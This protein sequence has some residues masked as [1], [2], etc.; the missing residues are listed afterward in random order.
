MR[1]EC[2]RFYTGEGIRWQFVNSPRKGN[3]C[4][5]LWGKTQES[6][7]RTLEEVIGK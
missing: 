1:S 7:A 6:I 4:D 3:S 2:R 5:M